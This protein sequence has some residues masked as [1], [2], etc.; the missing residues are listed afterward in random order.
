M[1]IIKRFTAGP[2][3]VS[4]LD[5]CYSFRGIAPFISLQSKEFDDNYRVMCNQ[6][7][8]FFRVRIKKKARK[9]FRK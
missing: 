3:M 5:K 7:L 9:I 1:E 8:T 4:G 6:E 2:F